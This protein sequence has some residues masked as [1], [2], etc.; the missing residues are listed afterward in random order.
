[1]GDAFQWRFKA[2]IIYLILVAIVNPRMIRKT[3][4]NVVI[5]IIEDSSGHIL[6][7]KRTKGASDGVV[8]SFPGGKVDT[9]ETMETA[10]ARE[11]L[12]ETGVECVAER[13]F[14]ERNY[15]ELTL[16]YFRCRLTGG[17]PGDPA[18]GE[19]TEV[20]FRSRDELLK[21]IPPHKFYPAVRQELGIPLTGQKPPSPA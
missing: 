7:L 13:K 11:V 5:A 15:P 14:A 2:P 4:Q 19:V 16:H 12:E 18:T 17:T 9:G 1:M 20:A 8:W 6:S 10:V 3:M 21:L